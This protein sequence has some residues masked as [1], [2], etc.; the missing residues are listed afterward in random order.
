MP[1]NKKSVTFSR[2]SDDASSSDKKEEVEKW[3][4][5]KE[6]KDELFYPKPNSADAKRVKEKG[7]Y[8]NDFKLFLTDLVA[9]CFAQN[10]PPNYRVGIDKS[11]TDNVDIVINFKLDEEGANAMAAILTQDGVSLSQRQVASGSKTHNQLV[12]DFTPENQAK[13]EGLNMDKIKD[14]LESSRNRSSS[15]PAR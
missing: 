4:E 1:R 9:N 14:E 8:D 2:S 11:S 12:I 7:A 3:E 5:Y 10:G 15:R 6:N 13:I